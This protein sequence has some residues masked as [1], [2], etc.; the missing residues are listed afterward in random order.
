MT[1]GDVSQ[2]SVHLHHNSPDIWLVRGDLLPAGV[3]LG[4]DGH[5]QL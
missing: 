2:L 5:D 4:D 1:S 3:P